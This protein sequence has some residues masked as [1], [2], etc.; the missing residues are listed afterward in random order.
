M[1]ALLFFW[2]S[3]KIPWLLI[4]YSRGENIFGGWGESDMLCPMFMI[5]YK[6]EEIEDKY[7][8]IGLY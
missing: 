5:Y 1:A 2:L 3:L 4:F 7:F 6:I 8:S